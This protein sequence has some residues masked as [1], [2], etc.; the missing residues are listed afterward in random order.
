MSVLQYW[1]FPTTRYDAVADAHSTLSASSEPTNA[2]ALYIH[3]HYVKTYVL[4]KSHSVMREIT[5]THTHSHTVRVHFG[6]N[7]SAI[8]T[9]AHWMHALGMPGTM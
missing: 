6:V 9:N 1:S 8:V 2:I 3:K 7:V 5:H 4:A